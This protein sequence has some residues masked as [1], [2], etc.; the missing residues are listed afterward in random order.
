MTYPCL[1]R[2]SPGYPSLLQELHD[3]PERLYLRGGPSE[4]LSRRAV[5]VVGARSCS[6]YGAQV[7]R[8]LGR[9]LAAAG[10]VVVSGLARGIDAEAHRGALEVHGVTVA[11]LGCGIDRDYPRGNAELAR[12]VCEHGL[13]VSEYG[14]G[15]EPAP[16]RFPARNRIV[17][18][19]ALA[20]IVVEAR[21]RSGALITADFALE[22]GREVFAVPGEITSALSAGTNGL[23]R[24][25][26]APVV[27][28]EDI[29]TA[30]GL[31]P[32]PQ[33]PAGK[34]TPLAEALLTALAAGS[35]TVD[36]LAGATGLAAAEVSAA[37]VSL[38]LGG[39]V[40]GA[41]GVYRPTV[42]S[43]GRTRDAPA[44]A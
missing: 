7:A 30:I 8:S 28:V 41:D 33:P 42:L 11:V 34:L 17:A 1:R 20:T 5:A 35:R 4:L 37:L 3:P 36:E 25:G 6:P 16:W 14:P 39:Q 24:Q 12:R 22:L 13:I 32:M 38:E 31:E 15:I 19:L 40:A 43:P 21:E 18:G 27:G 10:A 23:L 26:A 2:R 44:H 9:E 29:L